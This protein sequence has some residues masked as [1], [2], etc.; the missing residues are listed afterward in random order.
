LLSWHQLYP[1]AGYFD[2]SLRRDVVSLSYNDM[3]ILQ[4][5]KENL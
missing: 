3:K 5:L 4:D 2:S 1:N